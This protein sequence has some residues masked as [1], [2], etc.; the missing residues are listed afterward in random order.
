MT[1]MGHHHLSRKPVPVLPHGEEMF[2]DVQPDS[3]LCTLDQFHS[4]IGCQ[5]QSRAF[6]SASPPQELLKAVRSPLLQTRQPKCPQPLLTGVPPALSQL[7]CP[8]LD[9]F[10]DLKHPCYIAEPRTAHNIQ[11]EAPPMLNLVGEPPIF[12]SWAC[13]VS[14]RALPYSWTLQKGA[15]PNKEV[16]FA[17]AGTCTYNHTL[18]NYLE[19]ASQSRF[20]R[21]EMWSSTCWPLAWKFRRNLSG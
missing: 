1:D 2:P 18:S 5:E 19:G 21:W 4:A 6:L 8:P 15:Q 13:C 10:K 3:P 7:W 17:L 20:P 16:Q 11:G 12:T 9:A 14:D